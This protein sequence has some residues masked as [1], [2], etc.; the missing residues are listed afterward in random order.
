MNYDPWF[1]LYAKKLVQQPGEPIVWGP[2]GD[3]RTTFSPLQIGNYYNW[4]PIGY[5]LFLSLIYLFKL[6]DYEFVRAIYQM[7]IYSLIPVIFFKICKRYFNSNGNDFRP[8]ISALIFIINPLFLVGFLQSIDTWLK[9]FITMIII[10]LVFENDKKSKILL[11]PALIFLYLITPIGFLSVFLFIITLSFLKH[12]SLRFISLITIALIVVIILFGIRN[13]SITGKFDITNSS[14]GYN[15]WLG[16]NEATLDFL[17]EHLGDCATIEDKI[18]PLYNKKFNFLAQYSEYEKDSFFKKEAV[19]FILNHP[20]ITLQNMFWKMIGFWSPIRVRKGHYTDS[21]I[22]TLLSFLYQ[23]PLIISFF[24]SFAFFIIKKEWKKNK[25]KLFL[26]VLTF[27]WFIPYLFFF[28]LARYRTP[29]EFIFIMT[30]VELIFD[31]KKIKQL[32]L[33]DNSV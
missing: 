11:I 6:G 22:K 33:S 30:F 3:L 29:I 23:A 26:F 19:K 2:D 24:I 27:F 10:F 7:L 25:L 8:Q 31:N 17:K 12:F 4:R 1:E 15:L 18:I 5:S 28:T 20:I 16:N 32:I 9:T 13:Y 14:V 21:A